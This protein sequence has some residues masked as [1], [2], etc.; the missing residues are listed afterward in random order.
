MTGGL[1]TSIDPIRLADRGTRLAGTIP[2][3]R[4]KRLLAYC[5]SA[6]GVV[7]ADLEFSRD[8]QQGVRLIRGQVAVAIE[9]ICE[10]CLEPMTLQLES[11]VELLV[12]T[13]GQEVLDDQEDVLI[14]GESVSLDEI[15][16]NELILSMPMIPAHPQ[17]K[18][19]A[20]INTTEPDVGHSETQPAQGDDGSPFA[21]L[22]KLKRPNRE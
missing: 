5:H 19:T 2:L 17:D 7:S 8:R 3:R 11:S 16:E 14:A 22:E 9:I 20:R 18:C 4:M 13:A 12:Y 21:K 10:R 6:D 1:P 15:I